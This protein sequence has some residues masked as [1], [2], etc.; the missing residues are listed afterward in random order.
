[1]NI[2]DFVNA[3]PYNGLPHL[4]VNGVEFRWNGYYWAVIRTTGD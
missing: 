2:I 3:I 1:M 4:M